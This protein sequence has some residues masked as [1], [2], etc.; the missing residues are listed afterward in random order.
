M[1]VS[2]GHNILLIPNQ[3]LV[4][5]PELRW[6]G[7]SIYRD[8]EYHLLAVLQLPCCTLTLTRYFS[9]DGTPPNSRKHEQASV[10]H[11]DGT[12][13]GGKG[14][15]QLIGNHKRV[16]PRKREEKKIEKEREGKGK[17][18]KKRKTVSRLSINLQPIEY[19]LAT[20]SSCKFQLAV[21]ASFWVRCIFFS[22]S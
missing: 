18:E 4:K 6:R 9:S 1:C 20:F 7:A 5:S 8:I 13:V 22:I 19:N 17:K 3:M 11:G 16:S 10:N 21:T 2:L 12:V 14:R 15:L